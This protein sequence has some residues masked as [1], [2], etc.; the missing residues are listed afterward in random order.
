M[1]IPP[2]LSEHEREEWVRSREE[3]IADFEELEAELGA[4]EERL[5]LIIDLLAWII[6]WEAT[7][8]DLSL[9]RDWP[10]VDLSDDWL[11]RR[12]A[13][14]DPL[15]FD[16]ARHQVA[17]GLWSEP[18]RLSH[19]ASQLLEHDW[20]PK[21]TS[22]SDH[23]ARD[24]L[25]VAACVI[26]EEFSF[27]PDAVPLPSAKPEDR[28]AP[29]EINHDA[30]GRFSYSTNGSAKMLFDLLNSHSRLAELPDAVPSVDALRAAL[31]KREKIIRKLKFEGNWVGEVLFDLV[32]GGK[33]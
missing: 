5:R 16:L 9:P 13:L 24:F 23:L 30:A 4:G 8:G 32:H 26:A 17:Q 14:C 22:A 20:P 6:A 1:K 18:A 25:V 2:G 27:W 12:L 15:L 31:A 19:F 29:G 10:E 21:R 3:D 33:A 11:L 28:I 7:P